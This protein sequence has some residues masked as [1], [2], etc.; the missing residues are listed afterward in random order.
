MTVFADRVAVTTTSTGTGPMALGAALFSYRSW[1]AG[2]PDGFVYY[3]IIDEATGDWEIGEG[4][5][6]STGAQINRD[7]VLASSVGGALVS[8]VA[9]DKVVYSPEPGVSKDMD[10]GLF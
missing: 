5:L 10:Q 9:G 3:G 2:Y 7:V 4:T 8:F 1:A 6:T